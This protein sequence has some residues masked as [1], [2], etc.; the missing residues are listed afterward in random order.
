MAMVQN[1]MLLKGILERA[2][3]L[4]IYG[5][6]INFTEGNHSTGTGGYQVTTKEIQK[7]LIYKLKADASKITADIIGMSGIKE[8]IFGWVTDAKS[9]LEQIEKQ[10]YLYA[11]YNRHVSPGNKHTSYAAKILTARLVRG[12][13]SIERMTDVFVRAVFPLFFRLIFVIIILL[14]LNH[15][16]LHHRRQQDEE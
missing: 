5:G 14:H 11:E 4:G 6:V 8:S 15:F 16:H 3:K 7:E 1:L 2:E 13:S 12:R 10:N 9:P